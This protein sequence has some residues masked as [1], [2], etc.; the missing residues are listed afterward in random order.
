MSNPVGPI[1]RQSTLDSKIGML[2]I[3]VSMPFITY[4]ANA[5]DLSHD[6]MYTYIINAT[7]K[8]AEQMSQGLVKEPIRNEAWWACATL[9]VQRAKQLQW[10]A[11]EAEDSGKAG[12]Y[13]L[14][15]QLIW[16][17]QAEA[18]RKNK[19]LRETFKA[20]NTNISRQEMKSLDLHPSDGDSMARAEKARKKGKAKA[21]KRPT[22]NLDSILEEN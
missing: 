2:H 5:E 21:F 17:T 8:W 16:E 14:F 13:E 9:G 10:E 4:P 18:S 22:M 11:E 7:F 12:F 6:E 19:A 1:F 20:G 15:A 3:Q